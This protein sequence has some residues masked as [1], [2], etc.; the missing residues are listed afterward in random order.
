MVAKFVYVL[1]VHRRPWVSSSAF[2][3]YYWS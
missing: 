2:G 3:S 1:Q